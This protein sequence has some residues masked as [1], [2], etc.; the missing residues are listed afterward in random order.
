MNIIGLMRK[1]CDSAANYP[2]GVMS[3]GRKIYTCVNPY[4][5]LIARKNLDLYEKLDGI[6]I[7]GITMC[8]WIRFLH[9]SRIPRLSFDMTGM[10]KDLFE[11]ISK[12]G[13]TI[14]FIGTAQEQLEKSVKV[15]SSCYPQMVIAGK[16]NGYFNGD[17]DRQSA[18]RKIVEANPDFTVVGLGSPLQEHFVVDLKAAGYQGIAF[19]CGGFLHQTAQGIKYYPAWVDKYNLRAVYRLFHEKGLWGRLFNVLI[20]FP[21]TFAYDLTN[22]RFKKNRGNN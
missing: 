7:D 6:F 22:S 15:I 11:R 2:D 8:L 12:T 19:T 10:A 4:S 13:E 9:G 3:S 18:I 5:Y 17:E 1:I 14:Y 16:R 20:G 21:V